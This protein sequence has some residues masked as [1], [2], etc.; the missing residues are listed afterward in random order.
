MVGCKGSKGLVR[1]P[2]VLIQGLDILGGSSGA[3]VLSRS[4]RKVFTFVRVSGVRELAQVLKRGPQGFPCARCHSA[5]Y[6]VFVGSKFWGLRDQICTAS[7]PK[8]N[9]VRQVDL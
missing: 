2:E 8:I 5:E 4:A 9:Y 1:V 3:Q 6:E 7:D